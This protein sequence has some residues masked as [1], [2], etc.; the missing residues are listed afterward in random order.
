MTTM[1]EQ[2]PKTDAPLADLAAYMD[3][4]REAVLETWR[5]AVNCD[6]SLTTGSSLPG[7]QFRDHVPQLL[8][9][10]GR[11]LRGLS[12]AG[13]PVPPAPGEAEGAEHGLQ[14]WQQ[15]YRLR[16]LTIELGLL[17]LCVADELEGY[18]RAHPVLTAGQAAAAHRVWDG[19]CWQAAS[20]SVAEYHRL[21]QA[22]AA[23]HARD[24]AQALAE[25]KEM[26]RLR[27][28]AL[29]EAAHDLRGNV[30]VVHTA[31][32][33]LG[34]P[35][36]PEAMRSEVVGLLQRNVATLQEMLNDLMNLARLEAGHER[37][38]VRVFDA[39]QVLA[40]LCATTRPMAQERGLFLKAEGPANLPVQGDPTKVRRIAQ[41]LLLNALKY[42]DDGGVTVL[43]DTGGGKD[44]DRWM[45]SVRD[46]GPGFHAG[47]GAPLAGA[48]EEATA[49]VHEV[50]APRPSGSAPEKAAGRRDRRPTRQQSGESIGLS[51]V[52]RLCELL[53][54]SL[55]L[56]SKPEEG[57]VFRVKL[58]LHYDAPA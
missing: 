33:I 55:E 21:H 23:G 36:A 38:D 8:D 17:R 24:M 37:R 52:K 57:S 48:I 41:N 51:I 29:R 19:L 20:D 46:T 26:E 30:G 58:P 1:I 35:C 49:S 7:T 45:L 44:N 13:W 43:W 25:L 15:G 47:P 18:A 54:A 4:R 28:E 11:A 6:L 42:T 10:F 53:D 40:G 3:G 50:E 9:A 12:G 39:A 27:G 16:E 22:E 34:Q 5:R 56:E 32:S 31:A 14:R 2:T